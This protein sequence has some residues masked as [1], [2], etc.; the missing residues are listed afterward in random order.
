MTINPVGR[1]P[2]KTIRLP[3]A[4]YRDPGSAW[5]VTIGCASRRQVFADAA[6]ARA[7]SA[8]LGGRACTLDAGLH[9]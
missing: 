8:L 5:L 6:I 4:A 3:A 2:R 7:V 1:V 9:L